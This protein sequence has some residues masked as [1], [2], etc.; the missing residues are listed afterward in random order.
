MTTPKD[1]DAEIAAY[2]VGGFE[3]RRVEIVDYDPEWPERF[4]TEKV[5][6]TDAFGDAAIRIEHIGS[7]AVPG[8]GAKP[9]I[10]ILVTVAR[11]VEATIVAIVA[12]LGFELRVREADHLALRRPDW[13]VNLHIYAD[14]ADEVDRYLFFRDRLRDNAADRELYERTK[15]GLSEQEW[16]DVNHYAD[17]KGPVVEEILS[18]AIGPSA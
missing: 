2:L 17:A 10:D 5:L 8:L 4:E 18:R 9:V 16:P 14:D 11:V 12:P 1:L 13:S 15:R 6:L 7:T 3:P